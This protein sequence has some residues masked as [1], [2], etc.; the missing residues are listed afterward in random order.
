MLNNGSNSLQK[1][2]RNLTKLIFWARWLLRLSM[3]FISVKNCLKS[4]PHFILPKSHQ[5]KHWFALFNALKKLWNCYANSNRNQLMSGEYAAMSTI[6][7]RWITAV[8]LLRINTKIICS[9]RNWLRSSKKFKENNPEMLHSWWVA[10][11]KKS[12]TVHIIFSKCTISSESTQKK[13]C[14]LQNC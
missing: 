4:Q 8:F 1:I 2:E 11:T 14:R 13:I 9:Q 3:S 5:Y 6:R 10:L 7:N 12:S